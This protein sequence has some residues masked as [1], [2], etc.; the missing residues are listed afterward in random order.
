AIS[1]FVGPVV[2]DYL[3]G[4]ANDLVRRRLRGPLYIMQSNGGTAA[5]DT[6][7]SNAATMLL[8][9]PAAGVVGAAAMAADSGH[10]D[11]I[12][13]DIG[14]TSTDV[15]VVQSGKPRLSAQTVIAG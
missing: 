14:G 15:C 4:L 7:I 9:G 5:V 13:F 10:R 12:T 3:G 6:V 8:S 2:A 1:A 11:L